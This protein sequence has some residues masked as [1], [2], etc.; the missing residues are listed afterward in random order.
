MLEREGQPL[1]LFGAPGSGK[2]TV[3]N[4]LAEKFGYHFYDADTDFTLEQRAAILKGETFTHEMRQQQMVIV[5]RRIAQLQETHPQLAVANP[6]LSQQAR[7]DLIKDFP[8]S[9]FLLVEVPEV[10]RVTRIYQR[11]A[12]FVKPEMAI[13]AGTQFQPIERIP[14]QT[15]TNSG[16]G[17]LLELNLRRLLT[18]WPSPGF[19]LP[20]APG[21][22]SVPA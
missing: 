17:S 6:L 11:G 13:K 8:S 12:H 22:V 15:L 1:V 4:L 19:L 10:T 5:R 2:T 7:D 18:R 14:Y 16:D 21:A 3:G 9:R 20:T